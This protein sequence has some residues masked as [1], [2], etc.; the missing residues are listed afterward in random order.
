[1]REATPAEVVRSLAFYIVF[2]VF[3]AGLVI[4]TAL[5][6]MLG[7]R[8]FVPSV[9][10]WSRFHRWC[11]RHI[12]GIKVVIEGA[13]PQGRMFVASKH[14]SFFEAIDMPTLLP[15]PVVFAKAELFKVP[16]WGLAAREWG[17]IAVE[18]EAGAKALR[19][20]ISEA[21][22]LTADGRPLAIFP[23]G[24]RVRHGAAPPLQSGFAGIYKLIGLP[25]VPVAVNSGMLY[26]HRWKRRGTI[27][28]RIGEAIPPGLPRDEIEARVHEAI[29]ALN[30]PET[31]R[32]TTP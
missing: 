9:V 10:G 26:H 25:V 8:G 2:Y 3:S 30:T 20:M 31:D 19:N 6:L 16:L 5:L 28:I 32:T 24:T 4:W 29:N 18:R 14:E 7:G 17:N 12:L 11:V 27:I 21:R 22:R 13:L 23:E 15:H 1:V